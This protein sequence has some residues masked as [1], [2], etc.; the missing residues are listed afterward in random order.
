MDGNDLIEITR[1][2]RDILDPP[3]YERK[4]LWP[5]IALIIFVIWNIIL[6]ATIWRLYD[7]RSC[8]KYQMEKI[9]EAH[10]HFLNRFGLESWKK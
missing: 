3:K 10:K 8:E 7:Y 1:I 6:T 9:K 2:S 4:P 5:Y